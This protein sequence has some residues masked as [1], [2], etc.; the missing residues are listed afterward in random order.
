[1]FLLQMQHV[2]QKKDVNN[3]IISLRFLFA[4]FFLYRNL[5]FESLG[6][7]YLPSRRRRPV[8]GRDGKRV[9]LEPDS[10]AVL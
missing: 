9:T 1:M 5:Q 6:H 4:N 8:V 7:I 10:L 3:T 2:P